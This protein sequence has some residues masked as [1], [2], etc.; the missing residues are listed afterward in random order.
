MSIIE[1]PMVDTARMVT[2]QD[3][4]AA[5]DG[6]AKLGVAMNAVRQH[7]SSMD[8]KT[9]VEADL[10]D[11]QLN[12]TINEY[13]RTLFSVTGEKL[14]DYTASN[15]KIA[16]NFFSRLNTQRVMYSLGKGV[17]FSEDDD[18]SMKEELGNHFDHDLQ[19]A[20]YDAL[21]HGVSFGFWNVDRLCVFP[22]TEF[23]PLWDE[24]DGTL[25]A[26]V[27]F[28]RLDST[29]PM[30]AV[31]YEEDGYTKLTTR[32]GAQGSSEYFQ[33]VEDKRPYIE[34]V[35]YVPADGFEQVV[36]TENYGSLP[37]VPMWGSRLHQST[38]IGMKE[39]I[40]SYDLIR[41]GFANDVS[42]CSTIYWLI[43][44]AGGMTDSDLQRFIERMKLTHTAVVDSDAGQNAQAY[45]QEAPYNS[46]KEYL[47]GI[48]AQIYED[49]GGLDVH[50]VAAGATNDHI[51][52]A[53]QPLDE[54][55]SDFEYQVGEFIQQIMSLRGYECTPVF[56]RTRIS[57][58]TEQVSM[59]VQEAQWLDHETIL[60]KLPNIDES[61]VQDILD[62]MDEEDTQRMGTFYTDQFQEEDDEG[63]AVLEEEGDEGLEDEGIQS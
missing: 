34:R 56:K 16:S 9:A 14:V 62:R 23:A 20:A 38:L 25:R 11:R 8:Y 50:T 15:A 39:A 45:T 32:K 24:N 6:E 12:V 42:D 47:S 57:N 5:G 33:V 51:D 31:L 41:S 35:T 28:W 2:F 46:R 52:A 53:Y 48:R 49:F 30:Q 17:S 61:E 7:C 36:G 63:D 60:R 1:G 59:V 26:G 44:N 58:Q 10:Y 13:V 22:F 40:D 55:A 43:E 21:I 19:T 27:R 37:I 29:R 18:G 4:E 3:L 54:N